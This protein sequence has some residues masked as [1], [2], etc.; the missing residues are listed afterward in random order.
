MR[1]LSE[2]VMHEM[3]RVDTSPYSNLAPRLFLENLRQ[4]Y[5]SSSVVMS[6]LDQ[7]E[8]MLIHRPTAEKPS[9][10]EGAT[11]SL[12]QVCEGPAPK[13]QYTEWSMICLTTRN[14]LRITYENRRMEKTTKTKQ[15]KIPSYILKQD[16]IHRM[17]I[18]RNVKPV[19]ERTRPSAD[20]VIWLVFL[21]SIS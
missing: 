21:K 8:L 9:S 2:L 3:Y 7:S 19:N 1:V 11:H 20:L 16:G 10:L 15:N 4:R 13:N 17:A 12:V 18:I 14:C 5:I 6:S